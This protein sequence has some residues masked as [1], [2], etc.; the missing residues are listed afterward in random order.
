MENVM[1][2]FT[3]EQLN[4]VVEE[5]AQEIFDMFHTAVNSQITDA[6]TQITPETAKAIAKAVTLTHLKFFKSPLESIP[7]DKLEG[8]NGAAM[9]KLQM[10][11]EYWKGITQYIE[12]I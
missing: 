6:V 7:K 1:P 5:K 4:K 10:V 11:V 12:N 3:P 8:M 2:N 9:E